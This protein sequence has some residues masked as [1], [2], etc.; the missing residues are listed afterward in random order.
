MTVTV[1]Q[2]D[3]LTSGVRLP[4]L[5][6]YTLVKSHYGELHRTCKQWNFIR[7][8]EI[9]LAPALTDVNIQ[10]FYSVLAK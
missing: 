4:G 7:Q 5:A 3:L 2:P 1:I 8:L 6:K 9:I 10:A